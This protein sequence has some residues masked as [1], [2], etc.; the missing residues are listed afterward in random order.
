MTWCCRPQAPRCRPACW[1]G[2]GS[3]GPRPGAQARRRQGRRPLPK[4]P[5]AAGRPASGA[6]EPRAGARLEPGRDAARRRTLAAAA[7][8]RGRRADDAS[9]VAGAARGLPG[10]ALQAAARTTTIFVV[11][12]SGSAALAPAGRGQGRGRAAAGRLLCAPRPAWRCW[13]SAARA[14]SCCCRR[15]ARW[16]A[17]SAASPGC[18][19]AAARRSAAGIDAAGALADAVRRKGETAGRGAADRRARQHRARRRR[20]AGARAEAD[21]LARRARAA[22]RPGSGVLL[23]DTSPQPQ[24]PARGWPTR[25]ARSTCRCRMP[26]PH[27]LSRAVRAAAP[28]DVSPAHEAGRP[29]GSVDGAATGPNRG[30]QPLRRAPAACAGTC[31]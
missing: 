11:D 15:R 6:G 17:P 19:A 29:P 26:M 27:A 21:A 14:P 25:W 3:A 10:H 12:A 9:R 5:R 24:P 13:P 1:P 7:P 16:C 18:R 30:G 23:I 22:R 31:R 2:C 20:R 4:A 28:A 8:A